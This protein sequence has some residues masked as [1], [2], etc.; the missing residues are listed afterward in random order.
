MRSMRQ[1]GELTLR[2]VASLRWPQGDG[3]PLVEDAV[4]FLQPYCDRVILDAKTHDVVWA[5]RPGSRGHG[6]GR[7]HGRRELPRTV[8]RGQLA[9]HSYKTSLVPVLSPVEMLANHHQ[10]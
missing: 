2:D 9:V 3:V 1:V 4:A 10:I 5:A 8:R 6:W 7:V